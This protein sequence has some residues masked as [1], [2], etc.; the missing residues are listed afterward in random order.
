MN[1][2]TSS[3][4]NAAL[5]AELLTAV[6][7]LSRRRADL[8]DDT[9]VEQFVRQGWLSWQGGALRVTPAGARVCDAVLLAYA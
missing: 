6:D 8:L 1:S 9:K 7:A 5:C 4:D 3:Q 2:V